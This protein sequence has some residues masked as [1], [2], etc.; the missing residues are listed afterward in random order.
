MLVVT[1]NVF[2]LWL[3]CIRS[4]FTL[5][6]LSGSGASYVSKP[7]WH[8]QVTKKIALFGITAGI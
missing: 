7:G 3:M 2:E 5:C 1:K 8:S 4:Q 6:H